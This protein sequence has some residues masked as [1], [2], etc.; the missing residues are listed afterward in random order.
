L[1]EVYWHAACGASASQPRLTRID[2]EVQQIAGIDP[3]F[4]TSLSA[5]LVHSGGEVGTVDR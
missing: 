4:V 2:D 3:S 5:G 1:G